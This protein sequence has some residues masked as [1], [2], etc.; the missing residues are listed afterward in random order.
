MSSGFTS[1][2]VVPR[3]CPRPPGQGLE[4]S[5]LKVKLRRMSGPGLHVTLNRPGEV[6]R[7]RTGSWTLTGRKAPPESYGAHDTPRV[8]SAEG[9]WPLLPLKLLPF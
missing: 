8:M 6:R 7:S 2:Y 5:E 9:R 4:L 3:L 1:H